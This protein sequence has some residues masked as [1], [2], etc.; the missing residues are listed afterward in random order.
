MRSEANVA[1]AAGVVAAVFC[2]VFVD[3]AVRIHRARRRR[4]TRIQNEPYAEWE[5]ARSCLAQHD[6][7]TPT[8]AAIGTGYMYMEPE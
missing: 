3:V 5:T 8:L 6:C 4:R 2:A 1:T 7:P